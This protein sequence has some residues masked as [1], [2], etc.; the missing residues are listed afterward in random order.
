MN[1]VTF[2]SDHVGERLHETCAL[3]REQR[4]TFKL[5]DFV[6]LHRRKSVKIKNNNNII[7]LKKKKNRIESSNATVKKKCN[8]RAFGAVAP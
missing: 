2:I 8:Q 1:R 7:I 6:G 3:N 5:L 4:Q